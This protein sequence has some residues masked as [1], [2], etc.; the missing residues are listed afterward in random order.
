MLNASHRFNRNA[1]RSL[2]LIL[3][4]AMLFT[5]LALRPTQAASN[6]APISTTANLKV[7]FIGDTG[8]GTGFRDV[9]RLIKA[10]GA[11]A[12]IHPGDFDYVYDADGFFSVVDAELGWNYPY[13]VSVGNHDIDTW[14]T[15]CGDTDN[16]YAQLAIDR[17]IRL[18]ITPD[19]WDLNDQKYTIDFQGLKLI[20]AGQS[21]SQSSSVYAPYMDAQLA[22]DQHIWRICVWHKNQAAMQV[23]TKP[24]EASWSM[25]EV[26]RQRGAIIA[27]AH[28]HSYSRTRTL[29][30][31]TNQTVDPAWA[32]PNNVR[33]T[34]GS[35]FAFVSGLGGHS[36]RSQS[37]CLPT[38][39]PYGCN[40]EWANIYSSSQGATFGALFITFNVNGD[41]N[42]AQGYFKAINGQV[43]DQ[44]SITA[45]PTWAS[46]PA[47]TATRTPISPTPTRTSA[48]PTATSNIPQYDRIANGSFEADSDANGIP[49]NWTGKNLSQDA[50][51]CDVAHS[52]GCS[53]RFVGVGGTRGELSQ[54]YN[55]AGSAGEK[56]IFRVWTR[57]QSAVNDGSYQ[58]RTMFYYTDG[59][60][61]S[62]T[63]RMQSGTTDWHAFERT[64][65]AARAY[66]KI[67]VTLMY[68]GTSGTVWYDDVALTTGSLPP[69]PTPIGGAEVLVNGS[70]ET[71]TDANNVPD[72]WTFRSI[73]A[74]SGRDCTVAQHGTCSV[75]I[76][77]ST[78]MAEAYQ[79]FNLTGIAGDA[80]TVRAWTRAENALSTTKYRLKIVVYHNDG[81]Y[82]VM[83]YAPAAGSYDWALIERSFTTQKAYYRIQVSVIYG[84][85]SGSVWFDS[86]SLLR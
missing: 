45:Q 19:N 31:M 2:F 34:A 82:G 18:G 51:S 65:S 11:H 32:D 64:I 16:C 62:Y 72:N 60:F 52:G 3:I 76:N 74:G 9:L 79:R 36:I 44:F 26:C 38:T 54:T 69:T 58:I 39:F 21:T 41:P 4:F 77:G 49:D 80:F 27:T 68:G 24:D 47:P 7:A 86:V 50:R 33:V 13:F 35:T 17:L 71:D 46:G 73:P 56:F 70:Y 81:T 22:N 40:G 10:E 30:S 15:G 20:F 83:T 48:P 5:A 78:Q 25:Y 57:S 23:G 84:E 61:G 66:R 29:T 28:E 75:H 14:H 55:A 1:V 8:Y 6:Q 67:V 37:R 43:I 59:T 12:V 63:Y 42:K 85:S 53:F